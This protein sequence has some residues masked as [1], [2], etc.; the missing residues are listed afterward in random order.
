MNRIIKTVAVVVIFGILIG[1][2]YAQ[3]AKSEDAIKY[4]KA[5]MTIIVQHFGRMGAMVKGEVPYNQEAFANNAAVIEKASVL[6]WEAFLSPGSDKGETA[7]KS[8]VLKNPS[9]FKALAQTFE[10]EVSKLSAAAKSGDFD[11]AKAR[12]GAVAQSCK[13]CH[14]KTK[15]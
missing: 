8:N 9:D 11:A 7:M 4:R 5:V 2:A 14:S 1:A 12:F 15:K 3:F 10:M 13:A 6:P